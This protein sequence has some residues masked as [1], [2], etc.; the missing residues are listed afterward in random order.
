MNNQTVETE[1][2][3]EADMFALF[4]FLMKRPDLAANEDKGGDEVRAATNAN[5]Y[6]GLGDAI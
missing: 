4:Q 2:K 5:F 3:R 1:C 6:R